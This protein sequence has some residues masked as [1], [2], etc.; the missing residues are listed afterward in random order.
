MISNKG[1]MC[2]WIIF[3]YRIFQKISR[4][5]CPYPR[6]GIRI[7]WGGILC[8]PL[9][10]L[11][12]I[13]PVCTNDSIKLH[14][15]IDAIRFLLILPSNGSWSTTKSLASA[16]SSTPTKSS[17]SIPSM[18]ITKLW[19]QQAAIITLGIKS[20]RIHV[21]KF[22]PATFAF[23]AINGTLYCCLNITV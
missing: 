14:N 22:Q 3:K 23:K 19:M 5:V 17:S 13:T 18:S 8:P 16:S 15:N 2:K 1:S 9:P 21:E 4:M 12:A 7:W 20:N 10:P 11:S 6:H